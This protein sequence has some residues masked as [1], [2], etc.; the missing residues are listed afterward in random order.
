LTHSGVSDDPAAM[1]ALNR[2]K[3]R[4]KRLAELRRGQQEVELMRAVKSSGITMEQVRE[5]LRGEQQGMDDEEVEVDLDK[6]AIRMGAS[7]PCPL[8]EPLLALHFQKSLHSPK[9]SATRAFWS[10]SLNV[11]FPPLCRRGR[12]GRARRPRT[13]REA[14]ADRGEG[15]GGRGQGREAA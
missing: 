4:K 6:I 11:S 9:T 7:R 14:H 5:A 3:A 10:L 8:R 15:Q 13:A 12:R 2:E 1:D